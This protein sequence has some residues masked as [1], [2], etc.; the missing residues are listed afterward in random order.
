[1]GGMIRCIKT[2]Y[3]IYDIENKMN[4]EDDIFNF[5]YLKKQIKKN[6]NVYVD[7]DTNKEKEINHYSDNFLGDTSI[8]RVNTIG[9]NLYS[10][11]NI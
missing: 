3:N 4:N 5:D 10:R 6:N 2:E 8:K 1:M 11:I 9:V 7:I